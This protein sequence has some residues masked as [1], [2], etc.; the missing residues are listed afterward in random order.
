MLVENSSICGVQQ[1]AGRGA[2]GRR[3]DASFPPGF[4]DVVEACSSGQRASGV[5]ERTKGEPRSAVCPA[6]NQHLAGDVSTD[7]FQGPWWMA[8]VEYRTYIMHF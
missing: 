5:D 3:P 6:L 1:G 7:C 4:G 2:G 8:P